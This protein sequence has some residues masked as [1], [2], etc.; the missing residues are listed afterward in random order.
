MGMMKELLEKRLNENKYAMY[1]VLQRVDAYLSFHRTGVEEELK[2]DVQELLQK[3]E[4]LAEID[5]R[6]ITRKD[7]E[8][9]EEELYGED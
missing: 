3:I 6:V 7:Y 5:G 4:K 8:K 1:D 9:I 2:Y